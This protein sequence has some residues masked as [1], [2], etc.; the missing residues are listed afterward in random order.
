MMAK[1]KFLSLAG[2]SSTKIL[3]QKELETMEKEDP[4]GALDCLLAKILSAPSPISSTSNNM[5]E[6]VAVEFLQG[7]KRAAFDQDLFK[8]LEDDASLYQEILTAMKQV[9]GLRGDSDLGRYLGDFEYMLHATM[10]GIKQRYTTSNSLESTR[11]QNN[12]QLDVAQKFNEETQTIKFN[13]MEGGN[14]SKVLDQ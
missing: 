5:H 4:A 13:L 3:G 11:T 12:D 6:V 1:S 10:K 14:K 2:T 8:A 9:Q 7:L